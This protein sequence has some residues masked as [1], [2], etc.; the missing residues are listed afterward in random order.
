MNSEEVRQILVVEDVP[1]Q[2]DIYCTLLRHH[3]FH[4]FEAT[5]GLEAVELA[6]VQRPDAIL[7]DIALPLLDG[8]GA[9]ERLKAEPSTAHIPILVLTAHVMPWDR[10]RSSQAGANAFLTKPCS[11]NLIVREIRRLLESDPSAPDLP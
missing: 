5:N 10:E 7:M 11:P 6:R 1:E 2:R 4:V 8:W 3:G 9:T